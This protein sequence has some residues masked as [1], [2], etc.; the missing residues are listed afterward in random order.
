MRSRSAY[1]AHEKSL[2]ELAGSVLAEHRDRP[3]VDVNCTAAPRR[4]DVTFD[5]L[6]VHGRD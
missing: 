4:L 1:P 3:W 6:V 2:L 5:R